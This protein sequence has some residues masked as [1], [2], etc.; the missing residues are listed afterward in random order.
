MALDFDKMGGI[1]PAI[2]QDSV[3]GEVLMLGF[4]NAEAYEKTVSEGRVSFFS[5]TKKRIW[6]KGEESGN[7]LNLVG[8]FEDCDQDSLL[9][10]VRPEGPVCHT[11]QRSCFG[12][13]LPGFRETPEEGGGKTGTEGKAGNLA[14][15]GKLQKLLESRKRELPEDSYTA[16]LFRAG[17]NKIAQKLG[18]EAVELVIE[19]KEDNDGRFLEESADL[20]FHLMI[21]LVERGYRLED[22]C[23][24]LEGRH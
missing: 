3:S 5:R 24:V 6:T 8:I 21:L 17:I 22:V 4:M 14:F 16:A 10:S 9:I 23:R 13:S 7:Y 15:L 19:A 12:E 18:E 11:G 20:L 2:I 1:L